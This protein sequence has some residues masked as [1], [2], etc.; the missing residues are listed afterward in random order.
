MARSR[1]ARTVIM[2]TL[3]MS[4]TLILADPRTEGGPGKV[5]TRDEIAEQHRWNLA[6]LYADEAAWT[7]DFEAAGKLLTEFKTHKDK[8]DSAARLAT[9]LKQRDRLSLK[10]ERVYAW[11]MLKHH[12]DTNEK[13]A[14]AS[15]ARASDLTHRYAEDTSWLIPNLLALPAETVTSWIDKTPELNVYR[16]WWDDIRRQRTHFRNTAE[17]ELLALAAGMADGPSDAFSLFTNAD[18]KFGTVKDEQG[19]EVELSPGRYNA[20]I[21]SADRRYRRDAFV[22]LHETYGKYAN[23][24]AALLSTQVKRDIFYAKSRNYGSALEASLGPNAIPVEVYEQLVAAIN[25]HA[26]LLHRYAELR[27]RVLKLDELHAYDLYVPLV[28]EYAEKVPYEAGVGTILESLSILGEE[29]TTP[30]RRAFESR[31]VDVYETRNK[32]SGAYCMGC[33]SA[34]PYLLLNYA[35]TAN[36]RSTVAHEMGHA[37]HSW[38]TQKTQPVIY[39][40]YTIFCAEVASTVNEALLNDYLL[41]RATKDEERLQLINSSLEGIRTTVFRQTL[42]AEFEKTIHEMAERGEPLTPDALFRVYRGLYQK[43]YGPAL[44][45]DECL[46][47]EC[48]RIPHFYRNFYVYQYATSYC[49]ATNIAS[50]VLAGEDGAVEGLMK[51]LKAGSS[52]YSL[53]V[54]KLAGV[55]MSSPKPFEDTMK[56]FERRLDELERLLKGMG[57][58]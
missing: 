18:L 24:L 32:R 13:N 54:L 51:F 52:D 4:T 57:K 15:Y 56:L 55:D 1:T 12:E 20:A 26:P 14:Q 2:G 47:A 44:V 46:D 25:R 43:Y 39:G 21:Y 38:F 29:Y 40:D 35:G 9:V 45:L 22:G 7:A 3:L 33:Y 19:D 11:A 36:D 53:N 50:R 48:L 37:M 34:H 16:H 17:E 27:Q 5:L 49:A 28:P 41:K 6:D 31:W 23:T 10:L 42:F 30:M 58:L 8:I